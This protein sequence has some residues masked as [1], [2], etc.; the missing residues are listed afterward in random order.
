MSTRYVLTA[1]HC[2]SFHPKNKLLRMTKLKYVRIGEWRLST[3]VDCEDGD[4]SPTPKNIPVIKNI[5][6]QDY[7]PASPDQYNDISL[8]VLDSTGDNA[9]QYNNFVR[10]IC[11]PFNS[12]LLNMNFENEVFDVAGWGEF[13]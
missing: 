2:V 5:T 8:I 12:E 3:D 6:H 9:F 4:C 13:D 11:L 10:P 7:L 1:A